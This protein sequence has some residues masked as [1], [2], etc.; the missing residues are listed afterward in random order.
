MQIKDLNKCR[1]P[2]FV[3]ATV[4]YIYER[5][6]D[7]ASHPNPKANKIFVMFDFPMLLQSAMGPGREL[8]ENASARI[9]NIE[10]FEETLRK[11]LASNDYLRYKD[12]VTFHPYNNED[13][14]EEKRRSLASRLRDRI[15][16]ERHHLL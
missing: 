14:T 13:E 7:E 8:E 10:T 5:E 12:L 4:H 15:N 6:E 1:K 2:P 11:F 9:R 3:K 16:L